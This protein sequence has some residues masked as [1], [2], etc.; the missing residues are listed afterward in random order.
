M[1]FVCQFIFADKWLPC[2]SA[3]ETLV[4]VQVSVIFRLMFA[5]EVPSLPV[6]NNERSELSPL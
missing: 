5:K 6:N 2:S 4:A 1:L 3:E